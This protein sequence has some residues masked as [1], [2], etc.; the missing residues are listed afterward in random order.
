M[1]QHAFERP[2]TALPWGTT[3][4]GEL[5]KKGLAAGSIMGTLAVLLTFPLGILGIVLSCKG[6]DRVQS[7]PGAAR[8]FLL[9]SWVLFAPG[10]IAGVLLLGFLLLRGVDALIG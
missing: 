5:T 9:W 1:T 4:A 2:T 3:R 10:T 7:D 6:L 8:K